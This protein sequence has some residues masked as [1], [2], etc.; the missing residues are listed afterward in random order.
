MKA[1]LVI[2]ISSLSF[3]ALADP[4]TVWKATTTHSRRG[5]GLLQRFYT[6]K[7]A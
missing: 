7:S 1:L 2:F 4:P 3:G 5:N 6:Q